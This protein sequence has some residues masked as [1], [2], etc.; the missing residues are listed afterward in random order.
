MVMN[1]VNDSDVV[2][3][4]WPRELADL[5]LYQIWQSPFGAGSLE[6]LIDTCETAIASLLKLTEVTEVTAASL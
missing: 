6:L 4:L 5:D 1:L 2:G 3:Y